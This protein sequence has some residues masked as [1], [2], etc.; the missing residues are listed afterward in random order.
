M[1]LRNYLFA[2]LLLTTCRPDGSVTREDL[3]AER[4]QIV[5]PKNQPEELTAHV[6]QKYY[7]NAP[8]L[9]AAAYQM[10]RTQAYHIYQA[11]RDKRAARNILKEIFDTHTVACPGFEPSSAELN[12]AATE[13]VGGGYSPHLEEAF[14]LFK[15][16]GNKEGQRSV[17]QR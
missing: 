14:E 10:D 8:R 13:M 5:C 3:T 1:T 12:S 6:L 9:R 17:A 7:G 2:G 11:L 15:K 16:T 4:I